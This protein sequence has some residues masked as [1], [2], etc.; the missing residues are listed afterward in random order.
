[1]RDSVGEDRSSSRTVAITLSA[2]TVLGIVGLAALGIPLLRGDP[3]GASSDPPASPRPGLRYACEDQPSA[4]HPGDEPCRR[5]VADFGRRRT[6]TVAEQEAAQPAIG[7]IRAALVRHT[8]TD[9]LSPPGPCLY[10]VLPADPTEVRQQLARA[11]Y[12]DAV[13]RPYRDGDP[14]PTGSVVYAVKVDGA[15]LLG[16]L[17]SDQSGQLRAVGPLADGTCVPA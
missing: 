3:T 13:V 8:R 6:L 17:P 12:P 5:I 9:C 14:A 15:C 7:T 4:D 2:F 1:M 10:R 11:G 16:Y